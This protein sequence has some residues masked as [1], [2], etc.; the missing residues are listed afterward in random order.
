MVLSQ[1]FQTQPTTMRW[2]LFVFLV[3]NAQLS[4][5]P[6]VSASEP[7]ATLKQFCTG[8][9][10]KAVATAGV[11]LEKMLSPTP[12]ISDANFAHWQKV[13]TV[14]EQKRMPPPKMPQPADADRAGTATWIRARLSEYAQ[15]NAG[16]PGK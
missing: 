3:V 4:A 2:C 15:K 14:L 13:A 11:N 6:A 16:D 7:T 12:A 1:M 5:A 10:G 9:H 8:C